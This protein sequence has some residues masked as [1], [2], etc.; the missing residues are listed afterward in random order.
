MSN[1]PLSVFETDSEIPIS[2]GEDLSAC[3]AVS[4]EPVLDWLLAILLAVTF[5]SAH[6]EPLRIELHRL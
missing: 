4:L 1:M 3:D 5:I 6:Y 2:Q